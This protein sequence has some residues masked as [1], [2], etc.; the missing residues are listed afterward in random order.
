MLHQAVPLRRYSEQAA[1]CQT[2]LITWVDTKCSNK[3]YNQGTDSQRYQPRTGTSTAV[4]AL[5]ID[6]YD[7]G[8]SLLN[9]MIFFFQ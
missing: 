4:S 3:S 1:A 2:D 5:T 9:A 6:I 8:Q 7:T